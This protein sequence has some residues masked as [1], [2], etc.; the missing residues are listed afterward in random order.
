MRTTDLCRAASWGTVA[1]LLAAC[2][3]G[4]DPDG[5]G[6][7]DTVPTDDTDDTPTVTVPFDPVIETTDNGDGTFTTLVQAT[8][9][10][11]W[12]YVSLGAGGVRVEP[13]DP[14]DSADWD[15]MFRRDKIY[16]NGG[17]D[18]TGGAEAASLDAVAID[19][20]RWPAVGGYTTDEADSDGDTYP[21][22]PFTGWFEYDI[23]THILSA[24]DR[25]YVLR[26]AT[27]TFRMRLLSYYHPT[28]DQS[29]WP[30][31]TWAP[32]TEDGPLTVDAAGLR[33]DTSAGPVHLS[34]PGQIALDPVD[35][36]ASAE[37]DVVVDGLSLPSNGGSSGSGGRSVAALDTAYDAVTSA[38]AS[39]YVED[40]AGALAIDGWYTDDGSGPVPV[41]DRTFVVRG[42]QGDAKLAV[43]AI[44]PT[45]LVLRTEA[46]PPPAE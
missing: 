9:G 23:T 40:A 41:P 27:G 11:I 8:D 14:A 15:L 12:V 42:P 4:T 46:F 32:L 6:P 44:D 20:I 19:S 2:S 17:V 45:G 22:G 31:F 38:P 37:W 21:N 33:V 10:D 36:A 7:T 24:A 25:S 39:G 1:A 29:G 28:G 18:G 5:T 30:S 43:E 34:L 26:G 16:L 3:G 35:P 13:A